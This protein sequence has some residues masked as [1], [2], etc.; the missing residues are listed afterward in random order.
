MIDPS[1]TPL[2]AP[3]WFIELFKVLGFSLHMV[4]MNLWYAGIVVAMLLGVLGSQHGRR[5]SA[6]LMAQMPVIIA[7]GINLGHRAAVVHSG[8][9]RE[10]LL[11]GHDPDGLVL[12]GRHRAA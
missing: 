9:L 6:R 4:P 7:M 2:P 12:A 3:V 1:A 11:S 8:R 10:D 5:F